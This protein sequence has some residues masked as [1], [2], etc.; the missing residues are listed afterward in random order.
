MIPLGCPQGHNNSC[1]LDLLTRPGVPGCVWPDKRNV[2][3]VLSHKICLAF[4]FTSFLSFGAHTFPFFALI[5][6]FSFVCLPVYMVGSSFFPQSTLAAFQ[7][8]SR[9]NR[10]MGWVLQPISTFNSFRGNSSALGSLPC[11][12][13]KSSTRS[14]RKQASLTHNF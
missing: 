12:F 2:T 9:E 11:G 1:C 7:N 6:L 8:Y 10:G 13:W 14:T 4:S 3:P 5:V